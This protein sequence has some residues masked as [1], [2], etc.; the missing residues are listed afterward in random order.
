LTS[1]RAGTFGHRTDV[2]Q[3]LGDDRAA[4]GEAEGSTTFPWKRTGLTPSGNYRVSVSRA[5]PLEW[6]DP[7]FSCGHWSPELVRLSGGIEG[8]GQEG[9]PSRM[10]HWDEVCAWQPD[11]V[12]I[13][14][15]GF[16]VARTLDDLPSLRAVP[17]WQDVPAVRSG[18]VYVVDGS[19]YFSRPGPRLV[20][21]L[22][23]LAH[24]LHP[25]VHPLPPGL[26]PPVR[27]HDPAAG[28]VNPGSP[29]TA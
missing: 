7:P 1:R 22:E 16:S 24:A 18:R 23:I 2:A 19:H 21:S 20:D 5:P 12:L 6:L 15:C 17:G 27:V 28:T 9:R 26:P 11:V 8:L 13:A 25:D 10:L 4:I 29:R 14:C 3:R